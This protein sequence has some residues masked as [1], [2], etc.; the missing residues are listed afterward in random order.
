MMRR[1]IRYNPKPGYVC[2]D[3]YGGGL[4]QFSFNS[5]N[6]TNSTVEYDRNG[7][8]HCNIYVY[9]DGLHHPGPYCGQGSCNVF[10]CNCD[11][12]YISGDESTA[13]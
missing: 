8:H 13:L 7:Q 11:D 4:N 2:D 5:I 1:V 3:I 9:G 6:S 10:G 12:G